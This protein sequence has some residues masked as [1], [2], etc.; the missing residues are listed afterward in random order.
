V[1]LWAKWYLIFSGFRTLLVCDRQTDQ[2]VVTCVAVG[3]IAF[4]Y[5]A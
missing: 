5:A 3:R 2:T 1:L 4:T